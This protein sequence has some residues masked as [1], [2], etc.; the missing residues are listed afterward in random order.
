VSS[1]IVGSNVTSVQPTNFQ[2]MR[3]ALY[4]P[5]HTDRRIAC[6]ENTIQYL[7]DQQQADRC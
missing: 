1:V 6:I 2:P 5:V 7:L 4:S 3:T